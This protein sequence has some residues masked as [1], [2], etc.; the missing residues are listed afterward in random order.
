MSHAAHLISPDL[1]RVTSKLVNDN[2]EAFLR[3]S[4]LYYFLGEESD[5]L[6][7]GGKEG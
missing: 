7:L 5:S 1:H 3:M 6:R 4:L 2:T